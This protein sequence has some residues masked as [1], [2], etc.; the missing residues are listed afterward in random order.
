MSDPR[1]ITDDQPIHPTSQA[2]S[3][4][5]TASITYPAQNTFTSMP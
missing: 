5:K 1:G 4:R 3:A 2:G